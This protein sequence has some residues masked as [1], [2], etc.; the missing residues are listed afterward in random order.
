M[1]LIQR[2]VA[3]SPYRKTRAHTEKGELGFQSMSDSRD[4][5]ASLL[6]C[7]ARI[8]SGRLPV[9][10][11]LTYPSIRFIEAHLPPGAKGFEFGGGMSTLWYEERCSQIHT[12][13]DNS[14]WYGVLRQRATRA[15][16]IY[17]KG[18]EYLRYIHKFD[19]HF[20]DLIVIDGNADRWLCFQHAQPHLKPGGLMVVDD[21]DKGQVEQGPITRLDQ[22]LASTDQYEVRR[23]P[24]WV[25]GC[26]WVK[27]TTVARKRGAA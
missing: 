19:D 1:K 7:G 24:G 12:V 27:E 15:N 11:W 26:L 20:F 16:L 10:P 22:V 17:V 18:D 8:L 9:L 3:G 23:F 2:I 25:P 21:T 13:E 4:C 6:T 14:E 5:A